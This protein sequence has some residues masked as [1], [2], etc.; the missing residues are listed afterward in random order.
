MQFKKWGIQDKSGLQETTS[1]DTINSINITKEWEK[2]KQFEKRK[3]ETAYE[4]EGK[5]T[6][7]PPPSG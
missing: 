4:K 1:D 5:S 6:G 3:R 7:D 2:K